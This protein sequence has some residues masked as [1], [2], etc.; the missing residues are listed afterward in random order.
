MYIFKIVRSNGG[1]R[2][3]ISAGPGRVTRLAVIES[4]GGCCHGRGAAPVEREKAKSRI[5]T[6]TGSLSDYSENY[7]YYSENYSLTAR[8]LIT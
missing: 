5:N 6:V 1:N 7:F 3:T 4:I 8:R 2:S